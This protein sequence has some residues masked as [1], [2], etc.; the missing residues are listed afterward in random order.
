MLQSLT[1]LLSE[2]KMLMKQGV[3]V[4][5]EASLNVSDE[6]IYE[7]EDYDPEFET[8]ELACFGYLLQLLFGFGFGCCY[9]LPGQSMLS[10]GSVL[11]V[12]SSCRRFPIWCKLLREG[13]E[14]IFPADMFYLGTVSLVKQAS[15]SKQSLDF[16]LL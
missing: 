3:L 4:N 2:E 10:A 9:S 15:L 16:W 1:W 6:G 11:Y 8:D 12:W 14:P 7:E 13:T 5:V